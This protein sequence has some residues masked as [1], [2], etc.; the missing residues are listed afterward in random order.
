MYTLILRTLSKETLQTAVKS[1]F[2]FLF[3]VLEKLVYLPF[4]HSNILRND[5][6]LV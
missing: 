5:P 6:M 1:S 4:C 3:L 2:I